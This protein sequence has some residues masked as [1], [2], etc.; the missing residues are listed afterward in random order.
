MAIQITEV[1]HY[2][3]NASTRHAYAR[4]QNNAATFAVVNVTFSVVP[5]ITGI[6]YP[7]PGSENQGLEGGGFKYWRKDFANPAGNPVSVCAE[8]RRGSEVRKL[9]SGTYAV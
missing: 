7:L 6:E 5:L 2:E 8:A 3:V 1:G 9:C 4:V